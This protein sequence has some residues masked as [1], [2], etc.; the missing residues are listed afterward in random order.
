MIAPSP[1]LRAGH[2]QS[3]GYWG[4][5]GYSRRKVIAFEGQYVFKPIDDPASELHEA[6][7][8][9][10]PTPAFKRAVA[11]VPS[12]REVDLIEV[13]SGHVRPFG[14]VRSDA[15]TKPQAVGGAAEARRR[16]VGRKRRPED[17]LRGVRPPASRSR[18]PP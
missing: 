5:L 7:T 13:F 18:L 15:D 14:I 6:R 16:K 12:A 9:A 1:P 11:D 8:L 2:P 17:Y 3:R 4:C 10:F